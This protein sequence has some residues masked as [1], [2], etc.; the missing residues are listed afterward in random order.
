MILY[1]GL[2]WQ[3][4]PRVETQIIPGE[5]QLEARENWPIDAALVSESS[6]VGDLIG[7]LIGGFVI[8]TAL[9][10]TLERIAR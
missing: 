8:G 6:E 4:Q 3:Q 5:I 1:G 2:N 9:G 7:G 10:F